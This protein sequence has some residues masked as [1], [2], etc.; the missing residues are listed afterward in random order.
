MISI[1]QLCAKAKAAA[2][3]PL[4]VG[5]TKATTGGAGVAGDTSA[6]PQKQSVEFAH[7]QLPPSGAAMVALI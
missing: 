3:L 2:V 1:G 4:A 7:A 5:P 6:P